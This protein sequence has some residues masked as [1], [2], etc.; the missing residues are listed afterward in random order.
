MGVNWLE[1]I[2]GGDIK[3]TLK[4]LFTHK[5]TT[6]TFILS[7]GRF[8]ASALGLLVG[9][10]V[11]RKLGPA[12]FGTF[13]ITMAVFEVAVVFTEIGI[14][15]SLVRFVNMYSVKDRAQADYYLKVGFWILL[16]SA[17]LVSGVG[18]ILSP[19]I[20][21]QLYHK[22]QL[23]LPIRLGFLIVIGGILWSYLL[24][25]LH[26]RE[27]FSRYASFSI[28]VGLLKLGIIGLLVYF[29]AITVN[30][31]LIVYI[32]IPLVGFVLGIIFTP[33]PLFKARGNFKETASSLFSFSKWI[34]LID[35]FFM[36]SGRIDLLIL[37]RYVKEEVLGHYS[38]AYMLISSFTILTSSLLNVLLPYV[39]KFDT[40]EQIREYVRKIPKITFCCALVLLPAIFVIGPV[41]RLVVGPEYGP[42][43]PLFQIMFFGFLATFIVDPIYL[44]VYPV[45]KPRL[46][47]LLC[48]IRL[49]V[50]AGSNLWLIPRYGALGAA[51]ASIA[52]NFIVAIIGISLIYKFVY[53]QKSF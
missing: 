52:T 30:N 27:L 26:A 48:I 5:I 53:K 4:N 25:S 39:C 19:T 10:L 37:G 18:L 12:G 42:T 3:T 36:L 16:G 9:T 43:I 28:I 49:A 32:I 51:T 44:V 11:A 38:M 7:G 47:S 2:V 21:T 1:S 24:S 46:L 8:I 23:I 22:P 34:F 17:L 15:I 6:N 35:F 29:A 33:T 40:M 41:V 13:S 31:V 14:G 50:S 20:A 45:N